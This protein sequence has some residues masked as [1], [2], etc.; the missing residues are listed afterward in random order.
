MRRE[1]SLLAVML[2]HANS[3][4]AQMPVDTPAV[5]SGARVRITV[6]SGQPA[7]LVGVF[8]AYRA[9]SVW[10]SVVPG[11]AT[12]SFPRSRVY[13]LEVSRRDG[14]YWRLGG[15][16]G[17]LIGLGVGCLIV[18]RNTYE[19][20]SSTPFLLALESTALGL[21]L[22][23]AIGGSIPRNRWQVLSWP[24]PGPVGR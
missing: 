10:L 9:D 4:R 2:V 11:S 19:L 21:A 12:V 22:G 24:T 23:T 18:G 20:G 3:T 7:R 6:D 1:F 14:S 15:G 16:L 13:R 5:S 8:A 17:S